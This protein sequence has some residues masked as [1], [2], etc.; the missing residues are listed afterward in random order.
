M[1]KAELRRPDHQFLPQY[2]NL[3]SLF[4]TLPG[5]AVLSTFVTVFGVLCSDGDTV[6]VLWLFSITGTALLKHHACNISAASC[7]AAAGTSPSLSIPHPFGRLTLRTLGLIFL[8]F[9]S[10]VI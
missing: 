6:G 10:F 1:Q 2:C 4:R 3:L 9:L 8:L 5:C 7:W